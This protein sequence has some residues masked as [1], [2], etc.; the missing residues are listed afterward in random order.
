MTLERIFR[1]WFRGKAW[2]AKRERRLEQWKEAREKDRRQLPPAFTVTRWDG[3]GTGVVIAEGSYRQAGLTMYHVCH[4]SEPFNVAFVEGV[5]HHRPSGR[6]VSSDLLLSFL[7]A[8][9]VKR[10]HPHIFHTEAKS[11]L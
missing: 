4:Y 9:R 6:A 2:K 3:A 11:G 1:G 5:W 8:E 10:K 7:E